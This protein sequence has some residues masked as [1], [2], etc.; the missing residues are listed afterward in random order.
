[1]P[2]EADD[3]PDD[4]LALMVCAELSPTGAAKALAAF[5][6][7][8]AVRRA[9]VRALGAIASI[10]HRAVAVHDALKLADPRAERR[11]MR[12]AEVRMVVLGDPDYPPQLAMIDDP[13]LGLWVRGDVGVLQRLAVAIVGARR[14]SSYGIAQAGRFAGFLA[15]Q[16]LTVV[17][18]GARGVDA[19]AHRAAL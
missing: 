9:S 19:Q 12:A 6:S 2:R 13:P 7:A 3:V 5:G 17:S 10:G 14:A 11:A 16:G 4:E 18:G 8:G 1:M 15:E